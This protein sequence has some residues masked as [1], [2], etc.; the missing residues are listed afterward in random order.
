MAAIFL[1]MVILV[2]LCVILVII[3]SLPHKLRTR[4]K[5]SAHVTGYP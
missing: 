4:I 5:L 2:A 3:L 1:G